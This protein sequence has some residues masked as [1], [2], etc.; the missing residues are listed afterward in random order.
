MAAAL[1]ILVLIVVLFINIAALCAGYGRHQSIHKM[2]SFFGG[3]GTFCF[4]G[5][6]VAAL[7]AFSQILVRRPGY[8]GLPV[9]WF[10][11]ATTAMTLGSFV[12]AIK[13]AIRDYGPKA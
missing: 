1:L 2:A 7:D 13:I 3:L 8:E 12:T 11:G 9:L 4:I 6:L 5:L 10:F